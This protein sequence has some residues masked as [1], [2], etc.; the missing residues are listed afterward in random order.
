MES[1]ATIKGKTT[2]ELAAAA[3][4]TVRSASSCRGLSG[5]WSGE[6]AAREQAETGG[7]RQ[8]TAAPRKERG[9]A[10]RPLRAAPTGAT[11]GWPSVRLPLAQGHADVT[12]GHI[13][14]R[15]DA[16]LRNTY[17]GPILGVGQGSPGQNWKE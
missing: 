14:C 15:E 8:R 7:P 13:W 2:P 5:S 10:L 16:T 11:R 1:K 6:D 9:R 12:Q 17:L 4:L 3:L